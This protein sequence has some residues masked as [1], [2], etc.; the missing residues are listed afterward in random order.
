MACPACTTHGDWKVLILTVV[1]RKSCRLEYQ[2]L[3]S[4][5]CIGSSSLVSLIDTVFQSPLRFQ[6]I[7]GKQIEPN[8]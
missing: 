7:A 1:S 4:A 8:G 3:I 5:H 2:L 6:G